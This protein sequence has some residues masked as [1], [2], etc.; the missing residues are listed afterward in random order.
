MDLSYLDLRNC[1]LNNIDLSYSDLT[2]SAVTHDTLF[3]TVHTDGIQSIA[4]S[5]NGYLLYTG[6]RDGSLKIWHVKT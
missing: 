2:G 5:S 4:Y 3:E 6:G 1:P